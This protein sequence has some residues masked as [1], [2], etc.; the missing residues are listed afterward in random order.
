MKLRLA[1]DLHF[2]FHAD[3]GVTLINELA[4]GDFDVLVVAGDIA[5]RGGFVAALSMLCEALAPRKLVYVLGNH[6]GYGGSWQDACAEAHR[7]SEEL[8]NLVYLER[9]VAMVGQRR[10]VGCTLWYPHSGGIQPLDDAISDFSEIEDVRRLLP[11]V[12]PASARFLSETV[13]PSDIVVT[14]HMP[15]PR[16]IARRFA[17]SRINDY[18]L[19]DMSPVVEQGGATLWIHGHTHTSCDY[20][21]GATRVL[22]NPFGYARHIAG[23]PNADYRSDLD[24]VV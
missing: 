17:R 14:H 9:S 3:G 4:A 11:A 6:E 23:E 2:E 5:N 1:S 19:H 15:H 8:E 22:C 20:T 12:A 24:L 16:S 18:F 7:L 13:R 21:A 10:F